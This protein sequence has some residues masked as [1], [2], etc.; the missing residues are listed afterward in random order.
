MRN[1]LGRLLGRGRC[2]CADFLRLMPLPQN[3]YR[4]ISGSLILKPRQDL[5][6]IEL[7]FKGL[8]RISGLV[9][10]NPTEVSFFVFQLSRSSSSNLSEFR[11]VSF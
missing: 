3:R 8:I 7:Q 6:A 9:E 10:G 11:Q 2:K 1:L 4:K 5:I